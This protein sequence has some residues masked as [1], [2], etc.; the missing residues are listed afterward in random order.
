MNELR[1]MD[2]NRPASG[3]VPVTVPTMISVCNV[4]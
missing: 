3:F 2:Y 4:T 1:F